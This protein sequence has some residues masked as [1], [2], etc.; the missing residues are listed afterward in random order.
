M[1]V[2]L[3]SGRSTLEAAR[4]IEGDVWT[5]TPSTVP[6]KLWTENLTVAVNASISERSTGNRFEPMKRV[7]YVPTD[8]FT[9]K[10]G[11]SVDI[12]TTDIGT[13][14]NFRIKS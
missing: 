4:S 3:S 2:V 9:R 14:T 8:G 12:K 7:L 5:V 1:E 6:R 13:H 10:E 11:H